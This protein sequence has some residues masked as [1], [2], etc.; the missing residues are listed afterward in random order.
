MSQ[1]GY[2]YL[3]HTADILVEAWAPK[4]EMVFEEAA[5]AMFDAMTDL[6]AIRAITTKEIQ[7][8]GHDLPELLYNWLEELLFIFETEQLLFKEF[9]VGKLSQKSEQKNRWYLKATAT[10]EPLDLR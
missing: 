4:L 8:S 2:R 6:K 3:D 5:K 1:R 9:H 7:V 10:G